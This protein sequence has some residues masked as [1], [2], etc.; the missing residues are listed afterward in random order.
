ML[1][2]W[3]LVALALNVW[4]GIVSPAQAQGSR[5]DD[6]VFN[7]RGIPLAGATIRVCAM[8]ASGQPCTPLALIYSDAALTQ[9]LANPTTTDGLGNYFFYAAPGKYEIEVSGPGITTKQLANVILPNDPSSPTFSS[10]NSSGAISAFSLN[11]SGNLTVNGNTTVIGNLASGT[12]NVSNQSTPPG[13]ANTGT[14]NLYTKTADK[15]LYYKDDT[16]AEIGPLASGSGAQTNVPNTFTAQQN[17]DANFEAK[18]PNPYFSLARYGGYGSS[19]NPSPTITCSINSSS[20][21][22]TCPGGSGDFLNGH[23]VVVPKAGAATTLATPGQPTVTPTFLL[24]GSATY[25]YQVIAEDRQGGLT[26]ASTAG[27]TTAGASTLGANNITLTSCVRTNGVATYTSSVAHNLQAGAQV[28]ISGFTGGVFDYC[29]GVKTIASTPTSTTFTTNDGTLAN[30]TNTTG[31]PVVTVIAC[32]TLTFASGSFSGANTI[33][34]W[35]YRNGALAG[36][37]AGIDPW[38]QDCGSNVNTAPSYVP[39]SPPGTAQPGYL[40]S[41]IVS[42]AGTTSLTLA[43]AAGST[44]SS[45]A[46]LH[47]NSINLKSAIQA[48]YNAGGSAV[49]ISNGMGYVPFNSTMDLTNGLTNTFSYSVKIHSNND[50]VLIN[51]PWILR[52]A[53]DIE[54]EPHQTTSFSYVNGTQFSG[55]ANPMFLIPEVNGVNGVHFN[56]VLLLVGGVQQT[57]I[58]TD[59]GSDGGGTAGIVLDDFDVNGSSG[60]GRPLVF[61]GGFDYFINRGNC[62]NGAGTFTASYCLLLTNVSSAVSTSNPSQVPGRF[63]VNGLYFAGGAVGIDCQPNG[64]GVA[65]TDFEFDTTIFESAVAPYLR[66]NCPSGIFNGIVF[67]DVVEADSLVGFGTAIVDAQNGGSV[68]S[69]LWTGGS[70]GNAGQPLL[71]APTGSTG[72]NALSIEGPFANPGNTAFLN[73]TGQGIAGNGLVSVSG[74]GRLAYGMPAPPAPGL[75]VGSGGS[76]PIGTVPYQIQW[77]DVD[78]NLSAVSAT[79]NAVVTTGNQTVTLTP[80]AA[81]AGAIG[82]FPYRNGAKA[83]V[84]AF[85]TCS[86]FVPINQAYVDSFSFVCGTSTGPALAGSSIVGPNGLSAPQLRLT[87]NGNILSTTFPSGLAA[88]RTLS[89]PDVTGYLPVTSYLNSAYDNATR[90]NGAIAANWT[91]TNNGININSNNFVGTAGVNDVAYWSASLFSP[92]QFSQVTLTALNG[93]SDFPGVA[94]LLSGSAGSTQGYSCIEDTTNIFIQK[95]TGTSNVTLTSSATTG[96]VGDILRLEAA[97]GGALTCYKNGVSTLTTTDTTYISGQPGLFL[98]GTTATSKNWSGGNLH[99]LAQLDVE[100]DW[101]KTQHFTQGM[102]IAGETLSSSP[103]GEQNVFLP[104]ALTSTWTGSTWTPDKAVTVTRLQ[105]QAKTAP[106][107]CTTNA[108]VRLTDGTSPVNVTIAAAANDSGSIVQNYA[109]GASLTIAVQTA[110][111]GCT[112]SPADANVIVQYRMQ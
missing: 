28:N 32:N 45:V 103:R 107:G 71:I 51:Q 109:A 95:I 108:I 101:A 1:F 22:L 43:K 8:P 70:V 92:S 82:Y 3:I 46:V 94:V 78:G 14:V 17:F 57:A 86:S 10:V 25:T 77:L 91:I 34:Y 18:G 80:P 105:V 40:A 85:G 56:R 110:A 54:G 93:T 53:I 65:P 29:N 30:E 49:Y 69:V 75:A 44:V 64:V 89:I 36:V 72:A 20:T 2:L 27:Q 23:G 84:A 26:A 60:L 96:V 11:L 62:Q 24:N 111:A 33:H 63:K 15:R 97:A 99:P 52:S 59:S 68:F 104:A 31:A 39:S 106:S 42:G 58:L 50:F 79:A 76:V 87:N 81:P 38:F 35:I 48:A 102:A 90:S 5:K 47:D 61:K 12:L 16:G 6:I 55:S 98:F 41:T 19:T 88:N 73:I 66:F 100:Q 37:A 112:T 67:R 83:N 7:T 13:A 74:S 4:P 9:A 21:T